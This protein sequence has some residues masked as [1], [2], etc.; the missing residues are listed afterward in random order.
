MLTRTEYRLSKRERAERYFTCKHCG[1]TGEVAFGAEGTSGWQRDGLLVDDLH[2]TVARAAEIDLRTDAMR[3]QALIPCPTC[4]RR[5]PGAVR[6]VAI[7]VGF[8]MGGAVALATVG[9]SQLLLGAAGCCG[10]AIWQAWRERGRLD[11]AGRATILKLQPGK[12]PDAELPRPRPA[13]RR[14][15]APPPDLP[16]ARVVAAP[17]PVVA[18]APDPAA[19]PKFLV[20]GDKAR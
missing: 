17:A 13:V 12:L 9:A 7:R 2:E 3:T 8:W 18:E 20:D 16:Q 19:P 5:A 15:L 14:Q 6:W 10:M 11:R 1:A 4:G